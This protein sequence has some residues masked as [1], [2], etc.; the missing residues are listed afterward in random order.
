MQMK[1]EGKN[2][3]LIRIG[4]ICFNSGIFLLPGAF[5]YSATLLLISFIIANI[6]NRNLLK[7]KWNYP[8]MLC[9]LLM[10]IVCLISSFYPI[11]YYNFTSNNN[12]NWIGLANWIPMFWVYWSA[13]Y[14][15]ETSEERKTCALYLLSGTVPIL[16]SGFGQYY[17][18]W[19]G[20]FNFFYDTII[21]YQ[22]EY[23]VNVLTGPFNNPNYAGTW[24]TVIF[25]FSFLFFLKGTRINL[26]KI[27]FCLI[28]IFIA[29][30]IFLTQS[31]NAITNLFVA[32]TL[33]IGISI[34]TLLLIFFILIVFI[35][36]IFILEIPIGSLSFF[37]E[38]KIISSF[39]PNTNK[40]N[41][42]FS[43]SRIKIW[44]TGISNIL[45]NPLIGWGASSF[46][47]LYLIKNGE[48]TFQHSHNLIIEIANNY[49]I[50]ISIIL[51]TTIFL[52]M[53]KSRSIL[54]KKKRL[55]F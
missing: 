11:T 2:K 33:L 22:R 40:F 5:I 51:F 41:D 12:L 13:Q 53:Y 4:R 43:F 6:K 46:S 21:W 16:I 27:F 17:F 3:L 36:S 39:M 29:F 10:I 18:N 19:Y 28:S 47:V 35:S 38:N 50:I 49:G 30:A 31:R 1:K 32:F 24:L 20:P 14:Y 9:S 26:N 25:P 8:L 23:A 48:P 45:S 42:I 55:Y 52:L 54:S 15:L 34:K 7:D 37:S 44:K